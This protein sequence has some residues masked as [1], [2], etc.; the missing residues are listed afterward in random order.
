MRAYLRREDHAELVYQAARHLRSLGWP[1]GSYVVP[2]WPLPN[3]WLGVSVENQ[4]TAD[5]RIPLLLETP[6]AH[7]W[8]S[9]EPLLGAVDLHSFL[10]CGDP[11]CEEELT[12]LDWIVVGGESGPHSRPMLPYWL[13]QVVLDCEPAGVK[14]YC[15]Q[16]SGPRPGMQG[17]L[18]DALWAFK[19]LPEG[20]A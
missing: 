16:D 4:E 2:S 3:I 10:P 12:F 11:V 7:R 19:Q 14:V 8:V 9:A 1:T 17:R 5:E 13:A 15:K 6:A 18:P 20:W